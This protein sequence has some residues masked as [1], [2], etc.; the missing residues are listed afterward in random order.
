MTSPKVIPIVAEEE[1]PESGCST[2]GEAFALMVVGDSMLPEFEEGEIIVIEPEGLVRDGSFVIALHNEE[3]IFRQ[4]Q[5]T[6]GRWFL[7]PLNP[8]F[9][10]LEIPGPEAIKGVI[11]Q[12]KK[13]GRRRS[14]KSYV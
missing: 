2:G 5:I 8:L 6:E 7:K 13:P 1:L 9:P 11:I 12:K 14:G 3:P 10:I 4:V